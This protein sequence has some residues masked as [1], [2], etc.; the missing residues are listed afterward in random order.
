MERERDGKGR[1]GSGVFTRLQTGRVRKGSKMQPDPDPDPTKINQVVLDLVRI[2]LKERD[3]CFFI[4]K[5]L[6][7]RKTNNIKS[8][9]NFLNTLIMSFY[10]KGCL[11]LTCFLPFFQNT[12]FLK[13]LLGFS[14][15]FI[16]FLCSQLPMTFRCRQ[17]PQLLL[18][19]HYISIKTVMKICLKNYISLFKKRV[20]Q[21]VEK[22]KARS[23]QNQAFRIIYLF[24]KKGYF[25]YFKN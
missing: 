8:D 21:L 20:F 16:I 3:L 5:I 10:Y 11:I 6:Q 24:L 22:I 15:I 13:R 4:E 7:E 14:I 12:L 18:S 25:S 17:H 19:F 9:L 23:C 2:R 1:G